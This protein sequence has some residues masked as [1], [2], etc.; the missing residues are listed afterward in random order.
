MN[1][2]FA[3][4]EY[5]GLD[6]RCSTIGVVILSVLLFG[7]FTDRIYWSYLLLI[8]VHIVI[9]AFSRSICQPFQESVKEQQRNQ[10]TS[11]IWQVSSFLYDW[12]QRNCCQDELGQKFHRKGRKI[13]FRGICVGIGAV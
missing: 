3:I 2:L 11:S 12:L 9:A 1:D 6:C 13:N 10:I 7:N 5:S 4:A 8:F